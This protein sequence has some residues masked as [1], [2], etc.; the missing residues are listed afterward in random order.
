MKRVAI[1]SYDG[2]WAMGVFSV[3]DFFRIVALLEQHLG[4]TQRYAVDVL[5]ADGAAVYAASGHKIQPDAAITDTGHYDLLVIPPIEGVR[6]AAGFT[7][8]PHVLTWLAARREAGTHLLAMTTGVC[9]LAAAGFAQ[10]QLL[11]THWAYARQ[12]KKCYP[13]SQFVTQQPFLQSGGIWSTGTLN[14]SFDALLEILAQERGDQFSQLCATHLLVSGPERLNPILPGHR[15]HCDELMLRLQGWI[16]LHHAKTLT[17]E[18]MAREVGLAERTLKRRFQQ[19]TQLSPNL[20]TQK[21]RIDKAKKLLLATDLSVK[22]IA[23][24]VGYENVSFF[25]RLFKTHTEQ[26]PAQWRTCKVAIT[27]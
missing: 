16:E 17:I 24:E 25:V 21:V 20:Y 1:L 10:H 15:N 7:P 4:L 9:F 18:R 8:E 6:L 2:C 26:T 12:L 22:A 11:A 3:T 23:Y 14:G 5:S 19:A 27:S 13:A